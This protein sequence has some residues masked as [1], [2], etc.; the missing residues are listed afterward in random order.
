MHIVKISL[1]VDWPFKANA[2][3]PKHNDEGQVCG[4]IAAPPVPAVVFLMENSA[5]HVQV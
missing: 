5:L 4:R 3:G 1:D 2:F